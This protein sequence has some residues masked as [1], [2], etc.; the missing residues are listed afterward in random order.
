M[1]KMTKLQ[2]VNRMLRSANEYPVVSLTDDGVNDTNIAE[3]VLDETNFMVQIE[4]QNCNTTEEER[5]PTT[6]GYILLPDGTLHVEAM[7]E[8]R[9]INVTVR[10]ARGDMKLYN[11]DDNTFVFEDSIKLKMVIGLDFEELPTPMQYWVTDMAARLYQAT[12]VGD[13]GM[14][15]LLQEIA[16]SSRA[17]ARSQDMRERHRSILEGT[18]A[19]AA[20]NRNTGYRLSRRWRW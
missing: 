13:F 14:D 16:A 2:A 15:R 9:G 8:D 4:G 3:D 18:N 19:R 17:L 12:T 5:H 11:V 1:G 10:G 6:E 20:V 7:D